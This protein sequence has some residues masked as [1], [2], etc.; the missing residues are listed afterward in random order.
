LTRLLCVLLAA[1]VGGAAWAQNTYDPLAPSGPH[2]PS[3]HERDRGELEEQRRA[4]AARM[5]GMP[6]WPKDENLIEFRVS[7]TTSFRFYIDAASLSVS[8]E[9][10]VRYTLV[11]RSASGVVNLSYEGMLCA[12]NQ[13]RIY[14]YGRDGRWA[15][16]SSEWRAIEPKTMQRWHHELRSTYFCPKRRTIMSVDEGLDALRRGGHEGQHHFFGN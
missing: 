7:N 4:A 12:E 15:A 10:I 2:V 11:A 13:Y 3:A 6:A 1:W 16:Q 5:P 8:P 14:A 9:R